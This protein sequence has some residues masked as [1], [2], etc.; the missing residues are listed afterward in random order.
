MPKK[1]IVLVPNILKER[2]ITLDEFR[3]GAM[4]SLNTARR[5]YDPIKSREITRFDGLSLTNIA[6]FLQIDD[7]SQLIQFE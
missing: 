3:W 7:I 6:K 1:I 5:W 2:G 4:L